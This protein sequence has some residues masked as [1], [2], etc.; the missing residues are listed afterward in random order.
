LTR[1]SARSG[2]TVAQASPKA[3]GGRQSLGALDDD[4]GP[5]VA[6]DHARLNG[7]DPAATAR[8]VEWVD[9]GGREP[10]EDLIGSRFG[11]GDIHHLQDVI[12]TV[13]IE[14]DGSHRPPPGSAP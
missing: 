7:G 3:S 2:R 8:V 4:A 5:L 1:P 12:V 13:F 14:T 9:G 6:L 11:L 10:D